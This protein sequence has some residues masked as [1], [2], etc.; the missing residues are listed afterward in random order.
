MAL[1]PPGP[2][3]LLRQLIRL[4]VPAALI[5]AAL[6]QLSNYVDTIPFWIVP[7]VTLLTVPAIVFF[8]FFWADL[9]NER[10][11]RSLGADPVPFV[12]GGGFMGRNIIKMLQEHGEAMYPS[13]LYGPLPQMYGGIFSLKIVLHDL[14]FTMEPAYIKAIL[15]TQFENFQKGPMFIKN[16][17]PVLGNGIFNADSDMWKFHRALTRPFFTRDRITDFETFERHADKAISITRTRL[18]EGQP[19][20]FQDLI[21]RFTL[22][23]ASSFLLGKEMNS[24]SLPL[25]YPTSNY[26]RLPPNA[27]PH[28][29]ADSFNESLSLAQKVS[30]GRQILGG[31][32]PLVEMWEDKLED[33]MAV[34]HNFIEPV[35]QEAMERKQGGFEKG[36]AECLTML[37][38]LVRQTDD[39]TL[40]RDE[41]INMLVAGKDTTS[42]TL[43]FA[44]YMLSEHPHVMTRLRQEV[45]D[46]VGPDRTPTYAD[47]KDMKYL[48]AVINECL[49]LYPPVPLN[50]R[51]A[52]KATTFPPLTP[53]GK[54]IFIPEG[55]TIVYS[56]FYMHRRR[57]LWGPDALE[58]DPDRFIDSRLQKYFLPNPWIFLPFNAGP[59][60]CL[61]QQFAYNQMSFF[62]IRLLQSFSSISLDLSARPDSTRPPE[63][64][65]LT[66]EGRQAKEKLLTDAHLTLFIK[67][68]MWV[69]MK[70]ATDN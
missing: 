44:T 17:R 69:Q 38:E 42:C 37:D 34:I 1:L 61:G 3:F 7:I 32:W 62:L 19:I 8:P 70:E 21:G 43:T 26:S 23:T 41:T 50:S 49:R 28:P 22:D 35:I 27:N 64:W 13:D 66:K 55:A 67:D 51:R 60:I 31:A 52:A 63:A 4:G 33:P 58:F 30:S 59:R 20:D 16:F 47:L 5:Y 54:L 10:R 53:G 29:H 68:A 46:T 11:R 18:R 24:L 56:V 6:N 12:T 36:E 48:R 2:V 57:D 9:K 45:L 15:A 14:I 39:Q 40:I 25:P 65:K